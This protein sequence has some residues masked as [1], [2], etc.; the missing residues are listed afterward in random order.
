M[1]ELPLER[2]EQFNSLVVST[3]QNIGDV[4]YFGH[5]LQ[6]SSS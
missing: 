2:I 5:F 1:I 3:Q 4:L 6:K